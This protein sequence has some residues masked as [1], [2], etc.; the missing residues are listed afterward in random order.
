M[1]K[2]HNKKLQTPDGVFDSIKEYNRWN[3]LKLLQRAGRISDL[4]RQVRFVLIPTQKADNGKVAEFPVYYIADFV[5]TENG[6]QV[7]EDAKGAKT[8]EYV[9]KRKLMLFLHGIRIRES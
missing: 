2:Y 1:Q 8:K 4:Q 3:E 6:R 5:Y 9:I 7:V